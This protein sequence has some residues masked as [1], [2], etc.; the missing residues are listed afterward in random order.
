MNFWIMEK[1]LIIFVFRIFPKSP[2]PNHTTARQRRRKVPNFGQFSEFF[3]MSDC[4]CHSHYNI[5]KSNMATQ[6]D[7]HGDYDYTNGFDGYVETTV[8]P[9]CFWLQWRLRSTVTLQSF[10]SCHLALNSNFK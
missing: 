6:D 3:A 1:N 8:D 5:V 4:A 10:R 2:S 7:Q 9:G